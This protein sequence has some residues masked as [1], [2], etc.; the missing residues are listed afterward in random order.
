MIRDLVRIIG[1]VGMLLLGIAGLILPVMPGWIF[2]IP[3][4]IILADYFRPIRRLVDWA[5]TKFEQHE[6]EF[7]KNRRSSAKMEN[8][9][10]S[11]ECSKASPCMERGNTTSKTSM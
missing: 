9:P 7:V 3:G 11:S 8:Q 10:E 4:L 6:P 2:I 5:K 1:G